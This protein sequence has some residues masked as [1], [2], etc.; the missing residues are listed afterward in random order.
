MIY[1]N[2]I[3]LTILVSIVSASPATN[4]VCTS[5]TKQEVLTNDS[6]T[7]YSNAV[8]NTEA[9]NSAAAP[10]VTNTDSQQAEKMVIKNPKKEEPVT[11][12]MFGAI[13]DG[14]IRKLSTK[15][16]SLDAA[17]KDYPNVQDLDFTIDG[18]AFQ[19]AVDFAAAKGGGE[20]IA[21]KN[22]AINFPIETKDDVT[23]D[24]QGAG[25]IYNDNSR[26]KTGLNN[27][28]FLG[29]YHG[30]AFGTK[31][32][33]FYRISGR[34]KAG[35]DNA[36]LTDDTDAR[37][38]KVGQII[39][40]CS[41]EKKIAAK[42]NKTELPY[43]ITISRISKIDGSKLYFEHP[44]DEDME[45]VHVAANGN[46]DPA[47]QIPYEA[48]QNVTIRNFTIKAR[49]WATRWYGYNCTIENLKVEGSE[50]LV[51]GNALVRSTIKNISGTFSYRCIEVKTGAN[52]L[53]ID[54]INGV[55]KKIPSQKEPRSA[56][57]IGEYNRNITIKNFTI[58]MGNLD[59]LSDPVIGLSSRK[60]VIS[61]GKIYCKNQ[62][63]VALRFY[64][65]DMI[66][67]EKLGCY[68][69]KVINVDFY[70]S[71]KIKNYV[72]MGSGKVGDVDPTGNVV[73]N[74]N[75]YGGSPKTI[76]ALNGGKNNVLRNCNFTKARLVKKP[77]FE[78]SSNTLEANKF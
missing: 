75:F 46:F 27:A 9:V 7:V 17:Q 58:D 21:K 14:V 68:D 57:S 45:A 61:D 35:Q 53:T 34:I 48:V 6:N 32:F 77:S 44:V 11:P 67:D 10:M 36:N 39:M 23:I 13:G 15:Y 29:N 49:S 30:A 64:G 78:G 55:Y 2:L 63:M 60:T 4:L 51:V 37:S 38:F 43:Q 56:I 20:V 73:E 16:A 18:A 1:S 47:A 33:K 25:I 71:P 52:Y 22:Y 74:C 42:S 12:E 66:K 70:C 5:T 59:I 72:F 65:D 50:V 54:G 28:F 76:V 8:E 3:R 40:L 41:I 31:G 19:K 24:G 62:S 26:S 69:N